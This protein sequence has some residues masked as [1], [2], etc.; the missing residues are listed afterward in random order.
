MGKL[1]LPWL[2][3][4]LFFAGL[5][6]AAAAAGKDYTYLL[7]GDPADAKVFPQG[8]AI[9]EGGADDSAEAIRWMIRRAD[10]GDIVVLRTDED[11]GTQEM[12]ATLGKADSVETFNF[13]ARTA[14]YDP[15][16]L[17]KIAQAD[18]IFFA[19]G[20]QAEYVSFWKGTLVQEAVNRAIKRGVP[21]GGISAGLAILGQFQFEALHDTITSDEALKD[22]YALEVTLGKDFLEVPQLNGIITDSHFSQRGRLG[23]LLVF[24]S[25]LVQDGWTGEARGIGVDEETAVLVDESGAAMVTGV[26]NAVFVRLSRKPLVCRPGEPLT[27]GVFEV[28]TAAPGQRFNV[29]TWEGEGRSSLV[30]V[31]KGVLTV[32]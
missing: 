22:P 25:R 29:K 31:K 3:P 21:V 1:K 13:A 15:F 4:A 17:S 30:D 14:A 11:E 18:G 9:L 2:L 12:F 7:T 20:D 26:N 19:G 16:I 6:Q 27:A 5:S 32:R 10:G 8:G 24:I 23:R 28:V